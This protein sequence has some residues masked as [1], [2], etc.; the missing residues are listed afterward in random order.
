LLENVNFM[1]GKMMM[2][3][4]YCVLP[5]SGS[6]EIRSFW[7]VSARVLEAEQYVVLGQKTIL[8]QL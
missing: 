3:L 6:V 8:V 7:I 2:I 4:T 5:H 1:D